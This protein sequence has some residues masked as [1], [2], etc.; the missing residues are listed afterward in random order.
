MAE[1]LKPS[2]FKRIALINWSLTPL[3]LFFFA[4]PFYRLGVIGESPFG[5]N[6]VASFLFAFSFS[7]TI[8]HGH[9]SVAIGS[10]HRNLYYD[11]LVHHKW[12]V[13][14]GFH[15]IFISTRF[16]LLLLLLS[17][18]IQ[19]IGVFNKSFI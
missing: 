8:L 16:R 9:V 1:E 12:S 17:V 3:L 13:G 4:W 11:W 6:L 7:I 10:F 14:I 18:V 2:N 5:L 15:P 19:L